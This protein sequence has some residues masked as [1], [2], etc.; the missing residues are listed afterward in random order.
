MDALVVHETTAVNIFKG[1]CLSESELYKHNVYPI[2]VA[3]L[4]MM[5]IDINLWRFADFVIS[6]TQYCKIPYIEGHF[7]SKYIELDN[8]RL[9][10]SAK[11][12]SLCWI[13]NSIEI[14]NI[15]DN[16]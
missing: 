12:N 8:L 16:F 7:I 5:G 6:K 10:I 3:R 2:I 15:N 13:V 11:E 14:Y 4:M 9:R 1:K